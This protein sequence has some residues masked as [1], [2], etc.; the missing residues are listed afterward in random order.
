M[1]S[2]VSQEST[3]R[4]SRVTAPLSTQDT[5]SICDS[6]LT[7][8]YLSASLGSLYQVRLCW[9]MQRGSAQR[10]MNVGTALKLDPCEAGNSSPF[11]FLLPQCGS[12]GPRTFA[13]RVDELISLRGER[14]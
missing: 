8:M 4:L 1:P 9:Q 12:I 2:L 11:R 10:L 7:E 13:H 14:S 3:V 6:V 5:K